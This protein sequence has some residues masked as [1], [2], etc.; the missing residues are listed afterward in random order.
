MTDNTFTSLSHGRF[1]CRSY[2]AEVPSAG[3]VESV[4]RLASCAPSACNRQPWRI[5]LIGPENEAA[6]RAVGA[7]YDR[8]WLGSA[9]YY[10]IVCAVAGEAWVRSYDSKCHVDVDVAILTEHICLAATGAGLASCW[11]CNF[12]PA[13]L[14]VGISFPEGV[15]PVVI[16]PLGYAADTTVPEKKRK[17]FTDIILKP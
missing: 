6:R 5:M 16:L 15:E 2:S 13:L 12:D 8:P 11:V 7:A 10:I 17:N 1:S 4:L 14:K 9:P 3:L